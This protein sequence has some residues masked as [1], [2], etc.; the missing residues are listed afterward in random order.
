MKTNFSLPL[1][2]ENL[3]RF[4]PISAVG[5]A[6]YF[7]TGPFSLITTGYDSWYM[8]IVKWAI[9]YDN[10]PYMLMHVTMG[11]LAA[12]TVFSYLHKTNSVAAVHAMPFSRRTISIFLSS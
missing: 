6:V 11:C 3:K 8:Y 10:I 4:W 2:K 9:G 12:A 7:L 5:F 1:F